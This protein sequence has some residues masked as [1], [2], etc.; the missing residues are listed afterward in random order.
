MWNPFFPL[1]FSLDN[2][3]EANWQPYPIPT[4]SGEPAKVG[5]TLPA[6]YFVVVRKGF[7]HPEAAIK[8]INLFTEKCWGETADNDQ[9]FNGDGTKYVPF[10]YAFVQ[11]WPARKN[12]DAHGRVTAALSSG[13]TTALNEEETQ[14]YSRAKAYI[15]SGDHTQGW[16]DDKIFGANSSFSVISQYVANDQYMYNEYL[17]IPTP[18]MVERQSTLDALEAEV[19]TKIIMGDSIEEFDKFVE[20]WKKLGGDDI[21]KELNEIN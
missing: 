10:K 5:A 18:T 2:N 8:M 12:L 4:E 17:G 20:N 1:L 14:Y 7:E 19:F 21:T 9:Y 13:D 3:P 6:N 15:D 16:A 11:A